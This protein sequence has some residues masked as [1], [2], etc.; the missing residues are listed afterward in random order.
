MSLTRF[1]FCFTLMLISPMCLGAESEVPANA[2]DVKPLAVGEK[3]PVALLKTIEGKSQTLAAALNGQPTVV[4]F[5][6]GEWCP[7]CTRQLQGL[8]KV[9]PQLEKM[10]YQMLAIA[11]DSPEDLKKLHEN[12]SLNYTLLADTEYQAILNFKVAFEVEAR[13]AAR[14]GKYLPVPAVYLIDAEGQLT[15]RYFD[16]NYRERLDEKELLAAAKKSRS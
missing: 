3:A 8:A 7:Y 9:F 13:R 4:V 12:A 16:S 10:G 14:Q 1:C 15:Y 6:R 2:E 11:P 5:F